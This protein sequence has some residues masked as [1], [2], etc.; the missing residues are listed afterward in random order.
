MILS[1]YKSDKK[2]LM[3]AQL[4]S[5][6]FEVVAGLYERCPVLNFELFTG[7]DLSIFFMKVK[8]M[9]SPLK[10][11]TKSLLNSSPPINCFTVTTVFFIHLC[12]GIWFSH[13]YKHL[14]TSEMPESITF[15]LLFQIQEEI[16]SA[17]ALCYNISAPCWWLRWPNMLHIKTNAHRR[18]NQ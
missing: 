3:S 15:G 2:W 1:D 12:L 16:H 13:S 18:I 7:T 9:F 4:C 11:K 17:K 8:N 6:K 5:T 14:V 10:K